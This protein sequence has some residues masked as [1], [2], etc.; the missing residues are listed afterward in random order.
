MK[1][2]LVINADDFGLSQGT[3]RAIKKVHEKGVLTSAS[4]LAT[5]PGFEDSL[6]IVKDCP[7]LGVG[8]HFSLTW[9][10]SVLPASEVPDLVDQDRYFYP[11][12]ARLILKS[13][14]IKN[15]IQQV[16]KE[17]L[18]QI[19][20]VVAAGVVVDHL[21]SQE[22]VHMIPK[23]FPVVLKIAKKYQI[24]F[25]RVPHE[26]FFLTAYFSA[27]NLL[28]LMLMKMFSWRRRQISRSRFYGLL[29]TNKMNGVVLKR[30]LAKVEKGITEVLLHPGYF[31]LS[32]TDEM[33][34]FTK[35]KALRFMKDEGRKM[36][37][38]TLLD[39]SIK[40]LIKKRR[41]VL[42][43]YRELTKIIKR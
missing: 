27:I 30:I 39:S 9:G 28:K 23:I 38:R 36:E 12:Y 7:K 35:Q 4:L 11:G 3:N 18:A 8:V 26:K 34:D 14:L 33:F 32:K 13:I 16:E 42:T 25:I 15:F 20:K 6:K 22:H 19:G 1:R 21:D 41:I 29:Y 31:S 5:T 40:K 24:K 10:R 2:Y 37:L 43:N 17:F